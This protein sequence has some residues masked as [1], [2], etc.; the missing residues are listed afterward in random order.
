M[1]TRLFKS[2]DGKTYD[3]RIASQLSDSTKMP[4]VKSYTGVTGTGHDEPVT[5]N[6]TAGD[7]NK[8]MAKVT[9]AIEQA[10]HFTAN[11]NQR[12]MLANYEEHFRYGDIDKH[13]DS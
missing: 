13:K 10:K 12:Q 1:N 2:A 7:F 6:V 11:P 9:D 8:F 5:V 4:Y 3:L